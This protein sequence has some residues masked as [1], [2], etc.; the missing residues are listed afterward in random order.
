[1]ERQP[2]NGLEWYDRGLDLEPRWTREPSVEAVKRICCQRLSISDQS[3]CSVTFFA[4][5]TFNKLYLVES[6]TSGKLLMRVSLPVDP[7]NKTRG[8]VETLRFLLAK[9]KIPVPKVIAFDDSSNNE[10]GFEWIL[11]ELMPGATAYRRWRKLS[12]D[13]KAALVMKI[14][15]FQAQLFDSGCGFRCI[16]TLNEP[17]KRLESVGRADCAPEAMVS[18]WF[19]WGDHFDYDVPRGPFRSSHDWLH[20]YI[21][22]IVREQTLAMKAAE[23]EDEK[24][25]AEDVLDTARKL[26]ALLPKIFPSLQNSPERSFIWHGDLSL[27]NI[28]VDDG[29]NITAV[30]D[31]E[32]VSAVPFWVAT[33]V[34]RFFI[35]GERE[36]E[37]QRD[38]YGDDDTDAVKTAPEDEGLDNEGKNPLYWDHLMDYD[39]TQLRKVFKARMQELRPN[40]DEENAENS[41][42]AD[43]LEAIM[44][45][46]TGFS[47]GDLDEWVQEVEKGNFVT[48]REVINR[49]V[50]IDE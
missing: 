2:R 37:P 19:F 47:L 46:G 43:F 24:Q 50:V 1:M 14:A 30:I 27:Q 38:Q 48:L 16:G 29:G 42:R 7:G 17:K 39:M 36:E 31:W 13:Q 49:E 9:T 4:A 3:T 6:P 10:L 20:A 40:W 8:E 22:I 26:L 25:E 33:Q 11:M 45:C 12:M 44:R 34:P 18:R 32:C 28:L 35:H 5:G 15:E 41:L 23:D 21:D